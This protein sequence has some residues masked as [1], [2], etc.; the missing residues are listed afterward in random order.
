MATQYPVKYS[1]SSDR[2]NAARSGSDLRPA[3]DDSLHIVALAANSL[4][5]LVDR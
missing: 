1:E 3:V 4:G 5:D 2:A